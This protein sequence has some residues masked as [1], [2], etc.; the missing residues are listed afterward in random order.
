MSSSFAVDGA[1][2]VAVGVEAIG[3]DGEL[4]LDGGSTLCLSGIWVP[5]ETESRGT[6]ERWRSVWRKLIRDG[7]YRHVADPNARRDRYGCSIADVENDDGLSLA[8]TLVEAGWALVDP[9]TAPDDAAIDAMLALEDRARRARRGIW[10]DRSGWPRV[11]DDLADR[12][13]TRQIVEGRVR[14]TS[15][16]DR[17]LYLNFGADWRTDFT[18]RLDRRMMETGGFEAADY[19]GKKLRVRGVVVESRGPLIDIFHLKQIEFLP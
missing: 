17:Y 16:N 14:R 9:T 10:R 1:L 5:E 15:E 13:G 8:G 3:D 11:A 6:S 2:A 18:T 12:I 19:D 7:G 4:K